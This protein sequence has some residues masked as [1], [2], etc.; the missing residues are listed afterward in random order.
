MM[1][2]I[3]CWGAGSNSMKPERVRGFCFAIGITILSFEVG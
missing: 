2:S 1:R 3:C